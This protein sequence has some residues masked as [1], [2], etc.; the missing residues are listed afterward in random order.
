MFACISV[1]VFAESVCVFI[2]IC[3]YVCLLHF[4]CLLLFNSFSL[5][6]HSTLIFLCSFYLPAY[7]LKRE[8][9]KL[10]LGWVRRIG[11]SERK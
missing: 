11:E 3:V 9:Q 10:V 5:F 6:I 7:F 4:L 8:R 1:C 2:Y